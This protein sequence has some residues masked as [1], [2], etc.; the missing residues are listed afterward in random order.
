MNPH[1]H[2]SLSSPACEVAPQVAQ[3]LALLNRVKQPRA[4]SAMFPRPW[5]APR[6]ASAEVAHRDGLILQHVALVA[7]GARGLLC[8][9]LSWASLARD[10]VLEAPAGERHPIAESPR[11]GAA[12]HAGAA[13]SAVASFGLHACFLKLARDNVLKMQPSATGGRGTIRRELTGC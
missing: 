3:L 9:G 4:L 11:G 12:V 8:L 7:P 6:L 10:A 1:L 5:A 13:Q 2:L